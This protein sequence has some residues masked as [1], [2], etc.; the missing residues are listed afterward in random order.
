MMLTRQKTCHR[1]GTTIVE[2]TVVV[3]IFTMMM[4]GILEY[5]LIVYA[6]NLIDNAARE[7]AR[8]AVVN[9]SDATLISDTQTYVKSLMGG[10]DKNLS[11]YACNVYLADTNGNNIG[12]PTG[13]KFGQYICVDVSANYVP[14]T[15]G[16]IYLNKFTIR[17]KSSMISEA[18]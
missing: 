8:Y 18:N 10:L 4:F 6:S 5:C 14:I 11:G 12:A 7:G 13:A 17:S 1:R 15:P 2:M 16:L 9:A 3:T